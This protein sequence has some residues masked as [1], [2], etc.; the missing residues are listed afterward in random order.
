MV[1]GWLVGRP[2]CR[3]AVTHRTGR[4]FDVAAVNGSSSARM[5]SGIVH[6]Y[7]CPSGRQLATAVIARDD[8]SVLLEDS[9]YDNNKKCLYMK[10]DGQFDFLPQRGMERTNVRSSYLRAP[11]NPFGIA[12]SVG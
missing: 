8:R 6:H 10:F 9:A 1:A 12:D 11:A 2:A 7:R 4:V 5:R 3:P